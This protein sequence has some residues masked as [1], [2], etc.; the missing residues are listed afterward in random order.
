MNQNKRHSFKLLTAGSTNISSTVN[1]L[2]A[3]THQLRETG[4]N[5]NLG[6]DQIHIFHTEQSIEALMSGNRPWKEKLEVYGIPQTSII[7][8]VTKIDDSNLDRFR[9]LVEQLKTIV[10]PFENSYYY[11]D[12]T[13]G[14]VA[15]K[16]ILA[17]FA[18]VLD[19]EQVYSLEVEFSEDKTEKL[20][21]MNMFYDELQDKG[22]KI[23]YRKF[24]P[25]REF[26]TFGRLNY[27][28]VLRHRE[29]IATLVGHI[30]ALLPTGFDVSHLQTSLLS[31]IHARLLA[32]VTGEDYNYRHS[33]FS[34]SAGIEDFT[35][36]FLRL[37]V[38]SDIE[39][40][41]L[42]TK[43][44]DVRE[45]VKKNPKYFI[46]FAILEHMTKLITVIRNDVAHSSMD[47]DRSAKLAD[48]KAHLSSQV[49]YAFLQFII[50]C[51]SGFV[52]HRGHLVDLEVLDENGIEGDGTFYFGFDGDDTGDYM[53]VAF[54]DS[55]DDEKEVLRRSESLQAAIKEL[56]RM[57]CK[58]TKNRDAV[59]FAE[60][61]NI[62]FK[63]KYDPV[64]VRELQRVFAKHTGL[65]SSVGFGETLREAAIALRLAKSKRGDSM[66][67]IAL[68]K[69]NDSTNSDAS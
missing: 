29:L 66:I 47:H 41:T 53:E 31:G 6:F 58:H 14:I 56:K 27:T 39:Q 64:L 63:A 32:E 30:A 16:S 7:H 55:A 46:D 9:D 54:G 23:N 36:M 35:N 25:V 37:Y 60:G 2:I 51:L 19:I 43:L 15:L 26:D 1:A 42:G 38:S 68:K 50:R 28:E 5:A 11:I 57:I 67:G 44:E 61:D 8:H 4:S 13:S 17:I 48:I 3:A 45:F 10:N 40:K 33:I 69:T 24:P 49:G 59:I 12:I 18:Y 21:E 52:D 65:S 20:K 22:V 34:S 62:L